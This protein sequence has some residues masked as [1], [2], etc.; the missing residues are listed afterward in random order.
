MSA[1]NV[2]GGELRLFLEEL[3]CELCRL[4][5]VK[6][7]NT[8][9]EGITI[10]REVALGAPTEFADILVTVSGA[11]AYF[12]EIKYG[13]SFEETV[14]SIRRKYAVN[15]RAECNRLI[16]VVR[17]LDPAQLQAELRDYVCATLDLEI[18]NEAQL[19]LDIKRYY[20]EDI[21]S[22]GEINITSLHSSTLR[23]NWK[24]AFDHDHDYH[25]ILASAL[26]W[27]FSPWTL[28]RLRHP[29]H[30]EKLR[31][32]DIWQTGSYRDIVIVM[33][34]ISSFSAYVRDTP[35]ERVTQQVLTAFYSQSRQAVHE[36]GGMFYQFVGDEVVGLF[37]FPDKREGYIVDALNCAKALIHIGASTSEHWQRRID[38]AQQKQGVH[39]GIAM[40]ALNLMPL[41]PFAH[42]HIGFIGDP[43]NLAARLMATAEPGEV[44]TSNVYH[45]SLSEDN[46]NEFVE[47]KPVKAKNMGMIKSW[48]RP[49]RVLAP[50]VDPQSQPSS[51][52]SRLSAPASAP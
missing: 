27:H 29:V 22:L 12:V 43:L 3:C 5:H 16:V 14:R 47:N 18:W 36:Y 13:H 17:D 41:R 26:F 38:Q 33:A 10:A 28:K 4:K 34:D 50:R 9:A 1:Q 49:A 2:D 46:Q 8:T 51:A 11:P 45:Q 7:N 24:M 15:H 52:A 19:L 20:N 40:G 32:S 44:V 21:K 37:G 35:D 30:R 23:A 6:D 39:I 42:S 25:E 48:R 31:A